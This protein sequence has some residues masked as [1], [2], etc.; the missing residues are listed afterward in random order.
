MPTKVLAFCGWLD[1]YVCEG[2]MC[3]PVHVIIFRTHFQKDSWVLSIPIFRE[4]EA[5][6]C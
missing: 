5:A 6:L 4:R 1:V 3:V 2:C